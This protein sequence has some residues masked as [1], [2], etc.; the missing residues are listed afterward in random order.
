[1]NKRNEQQTY[2]LANG[3]NATGKMCYVENSKSFR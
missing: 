3:L 1:M 2:T